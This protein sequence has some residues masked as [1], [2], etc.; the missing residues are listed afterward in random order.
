MAEKNTFNCPISKQQD[1]PTFLAYW[2]QNLSSSQKPLTEKEFL[3]YKNE[4]GLTN[5]EIIWGAYTEEEKTLYKDDYSKGTIPFIKSGTQVAFP[6]SDTP[7]LL[8]KPSNEG[9]FMSQGDFKAYWGA[10]YDS[11]IKD[12]QYVPDNVVTLD[13]STLRTKI[14]PLNIRVYLYL[15]AGNKVIDVSP[16][17]LDCSVNKTK[18]SGYFTV[19][20]SPFY[21]NGSSVQN[22]NSYFELFN[23]VSNGK[24]LV[25]D[26][27]EKMI[28]AN[29]LV[30]IRFEHL[31]IEKESEQRNN[32]T[33]TLE[34]EVPLTKLANSPTNNT[35]WDMIGIVDNNNVSYSSQDNNRTSTIVGQDFSKLFIEDGS[36][37][38][39][40]R[41]VEGAMDHWFNPGI[42]TTSWYKRNVLSGSYDYLWAYSFKRIREMIWFIVNVMSNIGLV[43]N[44]VFEGWKDK[45]T[46][47]YEISGTQSSSVNGIWQ[48]VKVFVEDSVNNRI[49][50]DS[51]ISNPNGTLMDYLN[52]V[53]QMPFVEFY[54]DTYVDTLDLVIRQPPF[55]EAAI[56]G[57]LNDEKCITVTADNVYEVSLT[58]DD[59]AYSWYQL[60]VQNNWTGSSEYA[61]LAF[62]PIVFLNEYAEIFGNK[63]LEI[64]DIYLSFETSRGA[65]AQSHL[66]TLQASALNDL[67]FLVETNAYLP[68]TR[69]G[70]I[71]LNGDRRIKIGTFIKFELT[72]EFFY[73]TSVT[74]SAS[75]SQGSLNR[76]TILQVERGMYLPILQGTSPAVGDER[77][78]NSLGRKEG[79]GVTIKPSYFK[80]VNLDKMK[81][82][83]EKTK[84]GELIT[85]ENPSIDKEQFDYF[86]NR[87]MYGRG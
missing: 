73:V 68:F 29:D 36:Y 43:K 38:L 17:V 70:T 6:I 84:L 57:A 12:P 69:K 46:T 66:I 34:L 3:D 81:E 24:F 16:Y 31:Q 39:P 67:M 41:E 82:A 58:Y 60:H 27:L 28:Q 5:L 55:T 37:F 72:N 40:L 25:K 54:F 62:V 56:M 64:N 30:F 18:K 87:K 13:S 35:V 74:N 11:I 15:K 20:L 14:Q 23:T 44:E 77:K 78:D 52:R 85:G 61:S 51:S 80:I 48:I 53:C 1:V 71:I 50:V 47:S 42:E 75:F 32:G 19:T 2:Q 21:Y 26:Y 79:S 63:K 22:G 7:L 86:L 49:L 83:I 33:S 9:Q 65:D 76:Q 45:R 4:K 10:N 59:R 8:E